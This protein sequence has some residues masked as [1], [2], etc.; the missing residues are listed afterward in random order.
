MEITPEQQAKIDNFKWDYDDADDSMV[1]QPEFE[2]SDKILRCVEKVFE[3]TIEHVSK[4][5]WEGDTFQV[6]IPREVDT[7]LKDRL[8]NRW[9]E[10]SRVRIF[11][12]I[13]AA[14]YTV[15]KNY[16]SQLEKKI[17]EIFPQKDDKV[18]ELVESFC[19]DEGETAQAPGEALA[20]FRVKTMV[21]F[22]EPSIMM[23]DEEISNDFTMEIAVENIL[24][25][26][27]QQ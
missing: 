5:D 25:E 26:D 19:E 17:N 18:K 24:K 22:D 13:V 8:D 15:G 4:N 10:S 14:S 12:L 27:S 6:N 23:D 11:D 16:Q 9:S 1:P 21:L 3:Y 20:F 2:I 7:L